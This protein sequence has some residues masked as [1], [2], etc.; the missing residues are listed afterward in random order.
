MG[1]SKPNV[2]FIFPDTQEAKDTSCYGGEVP[3]PHIDRLAAEGM[4]FTRNQ[5]NG[6]L[7][8]PARYN[9][10]TGQYA[11]RCRSLP[12][13][14]PQDDSAFLLWNTDLLP[15][16][17]T[18]G[19]V[20]QE[21]GYKTGLSGKWHCG[22]PSLIPIPA[23]ADPHEPAVRDMLLENDCRI[24]EYVAGFGF[25]EVYAMCLNN[26]RSAHVP[27][28]VREHNQPEITKGA[29]DFLE[30]Y[31]DEPFFLHVCPTLPH[32]PGV[33]D[34]LE[35]G[36][37]ASHRGYIEPLPDVQ[38]SYEDLL[39]RLDALSS[40]GKRNGHAASVMWMDDGV[41]AILAKIDELGLAE[42]TLVIFSTDHGARG[43]NT[44]YHNFTPCVARWPGVVAPG[45]ECEELVGTVDIAATILDACGVPAPDDLPMDG[46]SFVPLLKQEETDWPDS[47]FIES[48]YVRAVLMKDWSYQ[49]VRFPRTLQRRVTTENRRE[50][51][52]SGRPASAARYKAHTIFPGY[53]DDDQLYDLRED[54]LE[55]VNL[56][57]NS[58]C[59][60]RLAEM[61]DRLRAYSE[62]LPYAFG[63]FKS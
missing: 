24:C 44:C 33:L 46:R 8:T 17:R 26:P 37:W 49:A 3:T 19:H 58:E 15:G 62:T 9:V 12:V 16:D 13:T 50:F 30:K 56:A 4:K 23:D 59:A 6:P 57:A 7:C 36:L 53:Y 10:L 11:S 1:I 51:T 54:P 2:V 55:Q 28:V 41:G 45:S 52:Q 5:S 42:N 60:E 27:E 43:K 18:I 25:D 63:E 40:G 29:L 47:L 20:L 39:A 22:R 14:Y 61:Q 38:P 32:A 31:R 48:T 21:Q 34:V 35:S